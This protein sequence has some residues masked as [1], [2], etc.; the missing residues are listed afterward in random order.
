MSATFAEKFL[1]FIG[2]EDEPN[3][4]E[5]SDPVASTGTKTEARSRRG[6][7]VSLHGAPERLRIVV[8]EPTTF[9]DAKRVA[10]HLKERKPVLLNLENNDAVLA[11]RLID[12]LSGATYAG[13]GETRKVGQG[14]FLF[15]PSHVDIS[16]LDRGDQE[17]QP[18]PWVK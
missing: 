11:Q 15:V 17:E 9:A 10:D 5:E 6:K 12:F 1:R 4:R 14:M 16:G 3:E 18:F 13:E 2:F 8:V 7:V